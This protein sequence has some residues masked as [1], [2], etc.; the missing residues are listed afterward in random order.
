MATHWLVSAAGGIFSSAKAIVEELQWIASTGTSVGEASQATQLSD[1]VSRLRDTLPEASFHIHRGDWG[2]FRDNNLAKLLSQLRDKAYDAED[3]LRELDD[4]VLRHKVED[5]DRSRAGQ[6]LFSSLNLASI[7]FRGT[8]ARVMETHDRLKEDLYKVQR[9][10]DSMGI[11]VEPVRQLMPETSSVISAP[12]VFGRDTERDEVMK[13]MGVTTIE[14]R[15]V[16]QVIRQMGVPLT[17]AATASRSRSAAGSKAKGTVV[18]SRAYKRLKG[19]SSSSRNNHV[20]E[21]NPTEATADISVLP[22]YGIGG[23]GKTTLAQFIY[24]DPRVQAHFSI[25]IWVCVSDLFDKKRIIKEIIESI[26]ARGKEF[27]FNPSCS[28]NA[29]QEELMNRLKDQKFL[30]VLDDIWPKANEEWETFS[31]PLRQGLQGSMILVTTRYPV[32]AKRVATRNCKPVELQGL[33]TAIFWDFFKECAFGRELPENY[34]ELEDIAQSICS[35]LHGSPL[36]AK[37]L[38]RLLNMDLTKNRWETIQNSDLWQLPHEDTEIL[39]ALRLSYLYLPQEMKRCFAFCSMFPKDYSFERHEIVGIWVAQGFVETAGN[40]GDKYLDELRRRF[41]FQDD[42]KF[43]DRANR[44]VMHDLIHDMAQSVSV[45]EC[46]LL[47]RNLRYQN[48]QSSTIPETVRHMSVEVDTESLSTIRDFKHLNKL[49]SLR[50]GNRF[51]TEVT[52]CNQLSNILYL[53]LKGWTLE[54]LPE[55]ICGLTSLRYLD[56]SRSRVQELPEKFFRLYSL[57]VIDAS[58]SSLKK[59]HQDVTKLIN[60]R[61]IALPVE[62]SK[63]LSRVSGLG[64]LGCLRNLSEFRVE[65]EDGRRV[66]ELKLMNQLSGKLHIRS[67]RHVGCKE[68]AAEARLV[69]KQ[70]LKELVLEWQND[71]SPGG[72][73]PRSQHN[74]VAEGLRPNPGIEIL[75]VRGF[76]GDRIPSWL[77]AQYLPSL[78]S[79]E[80]GCSFLKGLSNPDVASS[81]RPDDVVMMQQRA[82]SSSNA[83]TSAFAF[84]RLTSLRLECCYGL[85]NLDELATPEDLPSLK[86]IWIRNC[87]DLVS[88]PAH[89][90]VGFTC[91]QE[92]RISDCKK[93]LLCPRERGMLLPPSLQRLSAY[94]CG[95]LD[96]SFPA[97]LENLSSLTLLQ[98]IR[99][100]N[101]KSIPLDRM[102]P[103]LKCLEL[104]HCPELSSIGGSHALSSMQHVKLS[105]CP[106]LTEVQQPLERKDLGSNSE[107]KE[108][109]KFLGS[110]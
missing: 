70:Y 15:E 11:H 106:K 81:S 85:T 103:T 67:L 102:N 80:L 38:G 105:G 86:S 27:N 89:R 45:D 96:R 39:P 108:L 88:L 77:K 49:H 29:L 12:Q 24:N 50:F 8:K 56:I 95:G 2:R 75:R 9:T 44:Y 17:R 21:N 1:E 58:L 66:G 23:M 33:P 18:N 59:I 92:L 37:T 76:R 28:L 52:W 42:P 16:D 84:A 30:L 46:F 93:L 54:K 104:V 83:T 74:G 94:E 91:L 32:V 6:L 22:I 63:A 57:Q 62:G 100:L 97:C 36:A 4:E 53:S 73:T 71:S 14:R 87:H 98:L 99:C 68:A 47:R 69:D 79:L 82:G 19:S 40:E 26:P 35:R 65:K 109:L 41:L 55:S 13:T 110:Y 10:L 90:F 107:D 48:H 20:D 34:L 101:V 61:Y 7:F 5:A 64:K 25:T 72:P 43:P 60:L 3:L 31:A 51:S 78:R